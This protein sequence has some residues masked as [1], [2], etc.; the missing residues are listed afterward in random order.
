M[1]LSLRLWV[2]SITTF[3]H[4]LEMLFRHE[5]RDIRPLLPFSTLPLH[6]AFRLTEPLRAVT[7]GRFY[8]RIFTNGLSL[9]PFYVRSQLPDRWL[10]SCVKLF[11]RCLS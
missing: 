2:C 6:T 5:F 7:I 1:R 11:R 9:Q 8:R 4:P 3:V 10:E